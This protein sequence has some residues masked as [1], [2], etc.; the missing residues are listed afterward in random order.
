[1]PVHQ[2]LYSSVAMRLRQ[3]GVALGVLL[4]SLIAQSGGHPEQ[5]AEPST[6]AGPSLT[7]DDLW[8]ADRVLD[9]QIT[10]PDEDWDKLR[11]QG[12]DLMAWFHASRKERS[13]PSPFTYVLADVTIDG[14]EF[15]RVGLRKKGFVGSMSTA[16]PSLKVKF[17]YTDESGRFDGISKLTLNNSQ[18]D[19][20]L[21]SQFLGYALFNAAGS[22]A[23]RCAFAKVT[24]NGESLGVYTHVESIERPFC[25]R[26]FGS[27][28]GVLYE[29]SNVDFFDG[30]ADG[31]E[32]EFGKGEVGRKKIQELIDL[33]NPVERLV[34]EEEIGRVVD[35]DAFYTFWAVESLLC[36]WD[37]YSANRNNYFIYLNP[38]TDRFH[39]VPWGADILFDTKDRHRL[40]GSP[41]SV[42]VKGLI[43]YK[44]YQLPEGR[45]RLADA[46]QCLLAGCWNE[47]ALLMELDRVQAMLEPHVL[48]QQVAMPNRLKNVRQFIKSRRQT[49]MS[50]MEDG[51]P[52]W[53]GGPSF[54]ET[55]PGKQSDPTAYA[56]IWDAARRRDHQDLNRLLELE[57]GQ[58]S[59]EEMSRVFTVISSIAKRMEPRR[60]TWSRGG[61]T[62]SLGVLLIAAGVGFAVF[63]SRKR[64][65]QRRSE[66]LSGR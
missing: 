23:S 55:I 46:F 19:H 66:S 39:F 64:T 9:I 41:S 45:R 8:P 13:P 6:T 36:F 54:P 59:N 12:R 11:H 58:L 10:L 48:Q 22:P 63:F 65:G 56:A 42:W 17:N 52:I 49:V 33:L 20:S 34:T 47:E 2:Q 18:Q 14:V 51:L 50:E 60:T 43:G 57:A 21:V 28:E 62:L 40:P 29:G 15:P 26:E 35:L 30:W 7:S 25:Q 27:D 16:R 38:K 3:L 5:Q 4:A 31:F 24:V 44:L 53:V 61:V 1:M 37:G 32:H